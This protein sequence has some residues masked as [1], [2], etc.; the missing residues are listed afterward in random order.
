LNLLKNLP[1]INDRLLPLTI[2][3]VLVVAVVL[4][5]INR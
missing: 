3:Q 5:T 1:S 4:T 2:N